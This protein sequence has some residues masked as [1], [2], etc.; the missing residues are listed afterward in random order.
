MTP[1]LL[2]FN[3]STSRIT[4]RACLGLA[5]ILGAIWMVQAN[6]PG[7]AMAFVQVPSDKPSFL[8]S[9]SLRFPKEK[10]EEFMRRAIANSRKA[11]V[12]YKTGGAF[13]AVIVDN[14]GKVIADGMN[15]VV[16][17]NDPTWHAEMHAIRQAC[18]LL[19]KPKLDGC[20]L[21]TSSEPCPMCLA[22][23]YWAGSGWGLLRRGG[24]RFE[25]IRQF[26][27]RLHLWR[28]RQADERPCDLRAGAATPGSRRSVE[29]VLQSQG[30]GRLLKSLCY[31]LE[32]ARSR[33]VGKTGA[34]RIGRG[35]GVKD[36]PATID[37]TLK[38]GKVDT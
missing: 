16:A 14:E 36:G 28:I 9:R 18:A 17:Q 22:T 2:S 23:V 8:R 15:H 37:S 35:R 24:C 4:L 11:G 6:M 3:S 38:V 27:R 19:K 12:E 13:G 5:L 1:G 33:L 31:L 21:Y 29:G 32:K 20:I 34:R 10:H 30:Q 26:R 7:T 25:E